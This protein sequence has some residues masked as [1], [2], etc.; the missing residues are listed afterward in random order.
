VFPLYVFLE[1]GHKLQKLTFIY[2]M[3]ICPVVAGFSC[4]GL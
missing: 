4:R 2:G 1:Y 3:L